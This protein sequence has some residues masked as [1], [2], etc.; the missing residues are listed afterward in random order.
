MET[1]CKARQAFYTQILLQIKCK[2]NFREWRRTD[3][4]RAALEV[5]EVVV[6]GRRLAVVSPL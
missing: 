6:V 1:K 3:V 5:F 2:E 4:V